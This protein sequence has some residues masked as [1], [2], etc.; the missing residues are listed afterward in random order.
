M[1]ESTLK[2]VQPWKHP[3]NY[4]GKEWTGWLVAPVGCSRDSD[5]VERSNWDA[6]LE[7]IP[8]SETVQVVRER[9][10]AVGWVEWLAIRPENAA[11]VAEAEKIGDEI[12]EYPILDEDRY[13]ELEA[14][15]APEED[16]E[17]D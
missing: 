11:A 3:S 15:D 14:Q 17:E 1:N 5:N 8:E 7:R 16:K 9:H 13:S 2:H 4:M 12:E 6:Q 10:W